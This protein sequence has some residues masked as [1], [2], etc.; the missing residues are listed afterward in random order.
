MH[1]G[2][3]ISMVIDLTMFIE[4]TILVHTIHFLQEIQWESMDLLVS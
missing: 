2:L 3:N 1:A 4:L